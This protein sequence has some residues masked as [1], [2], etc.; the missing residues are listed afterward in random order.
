M[1]KA[2]D[3]DDDDDKDDEV[4]GSDDDACVFVMSILCNVC[5]VSIC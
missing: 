1:C 2:D 5:S 4:D 3:D